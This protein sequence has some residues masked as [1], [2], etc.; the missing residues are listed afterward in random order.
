MP[1]VPVRYGIEGDREVEEAF[2]RLDA[3]AGRFGDALLKA[4]ERGDEGARSVT[5]ALDE[6]EKAFEK[7][8]QTAQRSGDEIASS[9]KK[10]ADSTGDLT[11]EAEKL[12]GIVGKGI[13][14]VATAAAT[15]LAAFTAQG[16]IAAKALKDLSDQTGQSIERLQA[17]E[18]VASRVGTSQSALTA[19]IQRFTQ[20]WG[21]AVNGSASAT[22]KFNDLGIS[23]YSVTGDA[24]SAEAGLLEL[25]DRLR[26]ADNEAVRI[27]QGTQF[28][29]RSMREMTPLVKEGAKAVE[30]AQGEMSRLRQNLNDQ[31][32]ADLDFMEQR[33]NT[34]WHATEERAMQWAATLA[35][36]GRQVAE[37]F[38]KTFAAPEA[39]TPQPTMTERFPEETAK[40]RAL[41]E[42]YDRLN[43]EFERLQKLQQSGGFI[44]PLTQKAIDG[45]PERIARIT[46]AL[47]QAGTALIRLFGA[48]SEWTKAAEDDIFAGIRTPPPGGVGPIPPPLPGSFTP[49]KPPPGGG[50]GSHGPDP[51]KGYEDAR[52]AIDDY[53]ASLDREVE[54]SRL[55]DRQRAITAAGLKAEKLAIDEVNAAKKAGIA[56]DGDAVVAAAKAR[57]EAAAAQN[58]DLDKAKREADRQREQALQAELRRWERAADRMQD[59]IADAIYGGLRDGSLRAGDIWRSLGDVVRRQ[60]AESLAAGVVLPIRAVFGQMAGGMGLPGLGGPAAA[61]GSA[62]LAGG[63][64]GG[65]MFGNPFGSLMPQGSFGFLSRPIFG[66]SASAYEGVIEGVSG[67][68]A[69][70]YFGDPTGG[71][72]G[73][74]TWGQGLGSL[75]MAGGGAYQMTQG[76]IGN[77][78]AGG[79]SIV[80]AGLNL[81]MPGLGTAVAMGG[82]LLGAILGHDTPSPQ[83]AANIVLDRTAAPWAYASTA[84]AQDRDNGNVEGVTTGANSVATALNRTLWQI[85]ARPGSGF[86]SGYA[87]NSQGANT[88]DQWI[89]GLGAYGTA[90]ATELASGLSSE[91]AVSRLLNEIFSRAAQDSQLIDDMSGAWS[92]SIATALKNIDVEDQGAI[93]QAIRTARAYDELLETGRAADSVRDQFEQ[94]G[95]EF[96]ALEFEAGRLGLNLDDL[97]EAESRRLRG[98]WDDTTLGWSDTVLGLKDP[99]ALELARIDRW[100]EQQ[101]EIIKAYVDE[102]VAT[103]AEGEAQ[104]IEIQKIAAEQQADVIQRYAAQSVGGLQDLYRRLVYGDLSGASPVTALQGASAAF[105]STF[106]AATADGA[107]T[108]DVTAFMNAAD[109]YARLN[110]QTHGIGG[111]FRTIQE[112]IAAATAAVIASQGGS[113]PNVGGLAGYIPTTDGGAVDTGKINVLLDKIAGL[114]D[115]ITLLR[116]QLPQAA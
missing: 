95:E 64:A 99:K 55:S 56:I 51:R 78:I 25:I 53:L 94:L 83:A 60:I 107:T 49:Y 28:F 48:A 90:G 65:G 8:A 33:F 19:G 31:Q 10:A 110:L 86:Q 54:L 24:K 21:E 44:D 113:L 45:F 46:R 34:W 35:G 81:W 52:R 98:M 58:Y 77:L 87:L 108:Q 88:G 32:K 71:M 97:H 101:L 103:F 27:A 20:V 7:A 9:T 106:A 17:L 102:G 61:N 91:Q 2:K 62:G 70:R 72:F 115:E 68:D 40:V 114:I 16:F 22:R 80:G 15:A 116:A 23:L 63:A 5:E 57:A 96:R 109:Q 111:D 13:V 112:M 92:Q 69:A 73:G 1:N 100:A 76:G 47:E 85:G 11:K 104:K 41:R 59:T 4:G 29:G 18:R 37:Y 43:A 38:D 36:A 75:A 84:L 82:Q 105:R 26:Q 74:V 89:V 67:A 6:V 66:P 42:E 50:G 30:A 79:S 12:G 14:G 3:A 93:D 39:A